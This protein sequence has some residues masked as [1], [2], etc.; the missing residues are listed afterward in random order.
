MRF[1]P[2]PALALL[3]VTALAACMSAK[4]PA[5]E[6]AT[7][8]DS[9]AANAEPAL[10]TMSSA[11]PSSK[12]SVPADVRYQLSG[13]AL[14]DQPMTVQ[15]AV[16]PRV[17]GQNLRVEF[18]E[19]SSLSIDSGG[20]SSVEQKVAAAGIY[21]RTLSVTP[22]TPTGAAVRVLVSM[23]VEGGRYFGI[24]SIAVGNESVDKGAPIRN[25]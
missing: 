12:V 11:Q 2:L 19:S 18:P 6:T 20:G 9:H 16:V 4:S 17:A 23:E 8:S 22:R 13:P 10:D 24:F 3:S 14:L 25:Q 7:A 21:R 1:L 15:I 5:P